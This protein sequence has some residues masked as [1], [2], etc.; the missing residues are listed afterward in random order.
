MLVLR[1]GKERKGKDRTG[2]DRKGKD[3]KGIGTYFELYLVV[4]CKLNSISD[5][6]GILDP[7]VEFDKFDCTCNWIATATN[8]DTS[9]V[10]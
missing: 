10:H 9:N 8:A 7:H 3:G 4:L 1:K 5:W 6:N 2:Q